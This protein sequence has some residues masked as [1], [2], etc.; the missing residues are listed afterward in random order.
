MKVSQ[1]MWAIAIGTGANAKDR[2]SGPSGQANNDVTNA[3]AIGTGARANRDNAIAIGGGSNTDVGGTKQ[4][5]YT[6]PNNV[7]ASWAGGDKT[8]PG[9]VVS[10]GSKGYERQLKH[11][12]PGEVSAT[13]TGCN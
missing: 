11:V 3:I 10:F 6:L 12:A 5:S 9:D 1:A 7:V 13:S 8:L 2:L 4:S